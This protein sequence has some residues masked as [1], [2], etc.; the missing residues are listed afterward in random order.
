MIG[1]AAAVIIL[2]FAFG[3]RRRWRCRS[4]PRSSGSSSALSLIGFWALLST[5]RRRPHPR[6]DDRTRRGDRLRALHRHPPQATSSSD[7]HGDERIRGSGH[8]HVGGAVL[9]AGRTVVIALGPARSR[10][11]RW[12]PRWATRRRSPWWSRCSPRLTLLPALL[13]ALGPRINSLRVKLGQHPSDDHRP[14]AGPLGRGWPGARGARGRRH[15]HPARAGVPLLQPAPGPVGHRRRLPKDH[16]HAPGLRPAEHGIR[17]RAPTARCWSPRSSARRPR[18]TRR[19]STRSTTSSRSSSTS[20]SSRS[21]QQAMPRAPQQ[22]AQSRPAA[23]PATA[24]LDKQKKQAEIPAT[25]R[26]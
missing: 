19:T 26:G 23:D 25:I 9:F 4:S 16:D 1:L 13:G 10:G 12:S 21:S 2:L 15:G 11:S 14:T 20:S 3:R 22:Q 7:G 6:H 17:R 8:R 5:C 18:P 24:E